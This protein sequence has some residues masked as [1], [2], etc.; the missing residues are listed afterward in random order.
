MREKKSIYIFITILFYLNVIKAD[1][2]LCLSTIFQQQRQQS[3]YNQL[4]HCQDVCSNQSN[5]EKNGLCVLNQCYCTD[6]GI[7]DCSDFNHE[8]CDDVCH[9]LNLNWYG[10][11]V[12]SECQCF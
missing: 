5:G 9:R 8:G 7:G 6:V 11:C 12:K 3:N 2:Q 10:V 1:N 4:I